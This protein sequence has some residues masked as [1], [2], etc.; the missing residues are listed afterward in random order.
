MKCK[1]VRLN[2]FLK[3]PWFDFF[4]QE[5]N[6]L[7]KKLHFS[8]LGQTLPLGSKINVNFRKNQRSAAQLQLSPGLHR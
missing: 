3:F 5:D 8:Y 2:I 6:R 4:L 1:E 7:G